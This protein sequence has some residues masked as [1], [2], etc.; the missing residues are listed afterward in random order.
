MKFERWLQNRKAIT[1]LLVGGITFVLIFLNLLGWLF[2]RRMESSLDEELGRRLQA[3]AG[4]TAK[5]VESDIFSTRLTTELSEVDRLLL[6]STLEELRIDNQLQSVILTDADLTTIIASPAHLE[7]GFSL[8]YL[9]NDSLQIRL[10]FQ[11]NVIASPLHFIEGNLFKA[12]YAP[13]RNEL[14]NV[15]GLVVVEASA[16]FFS[17]LKLFRRS[18]IVGGVTSAVV[19]LL[20]ALFAWWTV[21]LFVR[22]Q[23]SIH[24]NERLA[25]MGQMAATVAHEIRNP[26][27]I[28][29]S[30]AEV[31][32]TRYQKH[33]REDELFDFIPSEVERLN[34]LVNDFLT[35]ARDKKLELQQADL[36]Q[37]IQ[38][39]LEDIH[40]EYKAIQVNF[41]SELD[42]AVVAHHPDSIRQVIL[43]LVRNAIEAM[44][45][46]G[47]V[48]VRIFSETNWGRRMVKISVA[49]RGPGIQTDPDKIFEPFFTTKASGSGLGLAVTKQ[50]IEKHGGMIQAKNREGGGTIITFQLPA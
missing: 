30:T 1:F 15:V 47:T 45:E 18:L 4:L 2:L 33:D 23:E 7:P 35:F 36:V 48:D 42:S 3:L 22:M 27:G 24:R 5:I 19:I 38:K 25:A 13:I 32:K 43:N 37:T 10:A 29:K 31:L 21:M 9:I 12:G 20:F 41:S 50:I 11:G 40:A 39:A 14:G 34:R 44:G 49:D 26:L 6:L 46:T 17:M 8:P 28:I 16:D